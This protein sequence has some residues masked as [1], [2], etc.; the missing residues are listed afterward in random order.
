M[1]ERDLEANELEDSHVPYGPVSPSV[2]G[3]LALEEVGLD[4][5]RAVNV[6]IPS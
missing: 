5:A 1:N 4:L 6:L 3:P 2:D